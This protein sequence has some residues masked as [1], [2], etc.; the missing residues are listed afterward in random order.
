MAEK[1]DWFIPAAIGFLAITFVFF[2]LPHAP[3]SQPPYPV[4]EYPAAQ[5]V[6]LPPA[7]VDT[8][9]SLEEALAQRES[10]RAFSNESI[11]LRELGNLLWAAQGITHDGK[12][13]APSAGALYPLEL[14]VIASRVENLSP[15]VWHYNPKAHLLEL[16]KE[17]SYTGEIGDGAMGQTWVGNAAAVVAYTAVWQRTTSKYG[18]K[19]DEFVLME[20][21]HSS[22]NL[23]LE[24][25]ALG[26]A[27]VAVGGIDEKKMAEL[28][29]INETVETAIYLNAIGRRQR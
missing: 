7:P 6:Q 13:T 26:L 2:I 25:T 28:L 24:A 3:S 8:G 18:E 10:G 11:S 9:I 23:L 14:Y 12:R 17:G 15:G 20:A 21:G 19:G 1:A 4:K 5:I 16:V 29:G 22:Q 27:N